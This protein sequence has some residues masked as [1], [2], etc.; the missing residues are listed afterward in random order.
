MPLEGPSKVE[1]VTAAERE[2]SK[3]IAKQMPEGAKGALAS[4]LVLRPFRT[5]E[6]HSLKSICR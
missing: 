2:G 5:C 4:G 3:Q 6:R 1:V